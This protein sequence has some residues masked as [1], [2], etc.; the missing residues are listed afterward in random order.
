MSD[1][2]TSD[3]EEYK[4]P[5][6]EYVVEPKATEA[7]GTD[8]PVHKPESTLM[9]FVKRNQRKVIVIVIVVLA[10]I[11][12]QV[13]KYEKN[14]KVIKKSPVTK[15]VK[16]AR[17]SPQQT[18]LAVKNA[19][20]KQE[21]A[22]LR[23]NGSNNMTVSKLHQQLEAVQNQL[24][25]SNLTNQQLKEAMVLM[26]GQ[27]KQVNKHLIHQ[28]K[29]IVKK[30][31]PPKPVLVF[32]IRALVD[33]RAWLLGS[34]G[35]TESVTVGDPVPNYGLVKSIDPNTG[36]ITTTSGKLIKLGNNDY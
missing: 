8:E 27:L 30:V 19:M 34:N 28:P 9:L 31:G 21:L 23:Q 22:S 13:M 3:D 4:Y 1:R 7:E 36:I 10:L 5:E 2:K 17:P 32:K 6:E 25:Q 16:K 15:T 26:L 24:S 35:L 20:L 11:F 12:F 14:N 18:S 33:G 29:V